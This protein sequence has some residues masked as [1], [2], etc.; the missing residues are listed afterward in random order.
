M[1]LT[2][3]VPALAYL[4]GTYAYSIISATVHPILKAPLTGLFEFRYAILYN[5][6]LL[7]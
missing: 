2:H 7:P 3:E 1:V 6:F 4:C 5:L